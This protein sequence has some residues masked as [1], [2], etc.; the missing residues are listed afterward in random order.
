MKSQDISGL[1]ILITGGGS[2]IGAVI[3]KELS[4]SGNKVVICGRRRDNL[5]IVADPN[6]NIYP[7][8]CDVSSEKDIINLKKRFLE[9]FK[10]VDIIINCAGIQ[11][12]IGRFDKT[13]S[14]LW[15][16]TIEINLF[17]TYYICK[18]F[19]DLLLKSKIRKIINFSGGGAFNPFPNYSA[20]AV[21]KAGVV[22]FSEN[23]AQELKKE[24][25]QVNCIAPG[26]VAT[27]IHEQTIKAGEKLS[28]E[29]YFRFTQEKLKKGSV[30]METIINCIKFLISSESN[31]L[32]GKTISASFDK[33]DSKEFKEYIQEINDSD[34]F[35]MR[36][37]N[38][39]NLEDNNIVK[40]KLLKI[41]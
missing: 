12:A 10:H 3:A 14:E 6:K 7:I 11:G 24:N 34:L 4:S 21:S 2:G 15:I 26:F 1:I 25:V 23:I 36:R 38:L 20:Y 37:I 35:N 19:L 18:H 32:N 41:P 8:K 5:Q 40:K 28:G 33:Y 9:Q 17:G 30:P 16:K 31:G 39:I 27:K 13:K 22:R 29:E